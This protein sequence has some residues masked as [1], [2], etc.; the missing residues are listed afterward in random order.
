MQ[1]LWK[2][3]RRPLPQEW[4]RSC[5]DAKPRLARTMPQKLP[6]RQIG[7]VN[8]LRTHGASCHDA[9]MSSERIHC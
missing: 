4:E 2:A 6:P 3:G 1:E 9:I 5:L 7:R 8:R